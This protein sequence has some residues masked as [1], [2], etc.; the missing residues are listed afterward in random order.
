MKLRAYTII[1]DAVASAIDGA[2]PYAVRRW[3][4]YREGS[5]P[6]LLENREFLEH[7]AEATRGAV[8]EAL[9]RVIDYDDE[10]GDDVPLKPGITD[11]AVEP[12]DP[13]PE[14]A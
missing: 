11:V 13:H 1:S 3:F 8:L 14:A 2:F 6:D 9:G 12:S 5:P 4:K 10:T 7:V